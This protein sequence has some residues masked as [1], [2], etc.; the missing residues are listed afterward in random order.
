[1]IT[2]KAEAMNLT[3]E[4]DALNQEKDQSISNK[5]TNWDDFRCLVNE[6][7]TLNIKTKEDTEAAAKFFNN[8]IQ[9]AGWNAMPEHKRT[10][11][12]YNCSILIKQQI[13]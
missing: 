8:T 10:L 7:L 3:L 11:K 13:E 6:K 2:L 5:H 1:L 12:T 9:C 4:E